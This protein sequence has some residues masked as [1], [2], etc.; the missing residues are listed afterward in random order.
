[1]F[2]LTTGKK[3]YPNPSQ[4]FYKFFCIGIAPQYIAMETNGI[5]CGP[6]DW[7]FK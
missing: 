5:T 2:L 3:K 7:D 6:V 1:M 4:A